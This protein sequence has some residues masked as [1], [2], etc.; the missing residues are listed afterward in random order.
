M[1]FNLSLQ[2]DYSGPQMHSGAT[3][4]LLQ[5]PATEWVAGRGG[6][7]PQRTASLHAGRMHSGLAARRSGGVLG[8]CICA[9]SSLEQLK[10]DPSK[11]LG[12]CE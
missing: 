11:L 12:V 1:N 9:F 6:P 4:C 7:G 5:G 8:E 3:T 10:F 2:E